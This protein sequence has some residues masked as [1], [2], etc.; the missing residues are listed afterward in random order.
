[1]KSCVGSG[2][3]DSRGGGIDARRIGMDGRRRRSRLR[4]GGDRARAVWF[5]AG[6]ACLLA[7]AASPA[8]AAFDGIDAGP[9]VPATLSEA[10]E[11]ARDAYLEQALLDWQ[12]PG[13]TVA[14]VQCDEPVLTRGYGFRKQGAPERVDENTLFGLGSTSKAF[15][16][17]TVALLVYDGVL[18]WDDKVQ[19]YLPWLEVYDPWVSRELN[20]RDLL[21]QRLGTSYRDE[22]PLRAGSKDARDQLRRSRGLAPVS[23]FRAGYVYS[24]N[25]FIASGELVAAVSGKPWTAFAQE[26][27]W[28]PL[29]MSRTGADSEFA[30][31]QP[32]AASPHA[33]QPGEAAVPIAWDYP[34]AVAVPSGGINSN[35][36][37]V[38]QWLRFQ[39][40]EGAIGADRL[41]DR[42]V[43]RQMHAPQ[44]AIPDPGAAPD[45]QTQFPDPAREAGRM[46]FWSY[47]M[48]WYVT[49]YRGRTLVYHSGTIDGFRTGIGLL[50]EEGLAVYV[51][52]NRVSR[53]PMAL[54]LRLFDSYLGEP[55]ADWSR[56][57]L[58]G[59]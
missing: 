49:E 14:V 37:D 6:A 39:L 12:T 8:V 38:A 25:M 9:C 17:A 28:E 59:E 26:R 11:S 53:L 1:M 21:T 31:A 35:A 36:V 5:L 15:A 7:V 57:Y 41:I 30:R 45:V 55:E 27:L 52:V 56:L 34:D 48:G 46:R 43:F 18:H 4:E 44:T 20:V 23:P 54:M 33:G 50:P 58:D 32:N 47:G 22:N 3:E 13:M 42:G 29:G 19:Q 24:N 51:N 2:F 16:A 10:E 40:S